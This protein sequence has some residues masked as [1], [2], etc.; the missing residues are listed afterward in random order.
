VERQR[1]WLGTAVPGD[2]VGNFGS[3]I[4]LLSQRA[5]YLYVEGAR[6]W[7]DTQASVTRTAAD[8]ADGLRDR[9]EEVWKEIV[10]RLRASE[11]RYRGGFSGV[12]V[13]PDSTAE[14]PDSEDVRLVM[15]HPSQPHSRGADDSPAMLFANDA[16]EHRGTSQRTNRNMLVFLAPDSKRLDELQEAARDYL[17]WSWVANRQEELNLSPQQ[18]KQVEANSKRSHEAVTARIAQAYHW[19]LVPE[20]ADPARPATIAVEKADGANERL[21]ERVTEKLNRLAL[22]AGS[23]AARTIRL[24]LDQRLKSVWDRG[25]VSVGDLWSYYCRYPYLTRLR[26]RTVLDDGVRSTLTWVMWETEGFAL[27]DGYDEATGRYTGLT[28]P[29]GDSYFGQIT[30]ATLL[31]APSVAAQQVSDDEPSV[32]EPDVPTVPDD[33]TVPRPDL[34]TPPSNTRFFGVFTV[35]PERYGRDFTRLS[36]EVLQ[37]LTSV[38][39][40]QLEVHVEIHAKRAEGFPDDKVRTVLENSRTLRFDQSSFE[41]Q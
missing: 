13:A 21:A 34:P 25:H 17:A 28:L 1:I 35:D 30:D 8:Y 5:T 15:L 4:D 7:Y 18:V 6:F 11:A 23:V 16:F 10:D 14:I 26:D 2:T 37:Q 41:D 29:G 20:Q 12:H 38:D 22:L 40:V 33:P 9:P 19:A 3:A 27:A 32:V 39:G 31:V 36:Q 24:D